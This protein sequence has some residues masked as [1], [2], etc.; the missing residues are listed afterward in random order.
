MSSPLRIAL[1]EY[2]TGWHDPARSVA[3]A[4]ALIEKAAAAGAHLVALPEMCTTGF[5]M[6]AAQYA[7]PVDG[8]SASAL[9]AA[10]R[11]AG[12]YVI[13]GI[14]TRESSRGADTFYN[15]AIAFSPNGSRLAEYRKQRLFA[16]ATENDTYTAGTAPVTVD[17][18]GIRVT[19]LICFDLRFPELFS[20][21]APTSDC[22]IVIASWPSRRQSHWETLLRARAIETQAYVA[23]VNRTGRGGDLDYAGGSAAFDPWGEPLALSGESKIVTVDPQ[24]VASTRRTFP[25]VRDARRSS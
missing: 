5:T 22:I 24:V 25:L 16:Y 21:A 17:I 9:A 7:E 19:P 11:R 20:A 15:S 18:D 4:T 10:A 3:R 12:V 14:A 2:D 1:G 6:D 8:P 13:A 23:G